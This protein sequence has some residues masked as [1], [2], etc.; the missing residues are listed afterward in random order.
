[1]LEK[2]KLWGQKAGEP[3]LKGIR[4][5]TDYHEGWGIFFKMT[6]LLYVL[7]VR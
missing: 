3:G 5:R 7:I 1:M 4:R 6:E 2:A